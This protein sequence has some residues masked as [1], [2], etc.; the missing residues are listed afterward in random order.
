MKEKSQ[1]KLLLL[2]MSM[3]WFGQYVYFPYQTPYLLAFSVSAGMIGVVI[4]AYGFT[5]LI[6]RIPLGIMADRKPRQKLFIII[7]VACVALASLIRIFSPGEAG[8]LIANLL[9]GIGSSMWIS[10]MT[11]YSNY[12]DKASQQKAMGQALAA[13]NIGILFGFVLASLLYDKMGMT[14]LCI[15]SIAA[16]LIGV[17]LSFFIKEKKAAVKNQ[18]IGQLAAVF[19][20]KRL[21]LFALFAMVVMGVTGATALAFT[22]QVARNLGAG[23]FEIGMASI[24]YMSMSFLGSFFSSTKTAIRQGP[25]IW[26]P[27]MMLFLAVYCFVVPN[28]SS[29]GHVFAIQILVGLSKGILISCCTAEGM[30]NVPLEKKTT[31]IGFFQAIYAVG[32]TFGPVLAGALSDAVNINFAYYMMAA[33]AIAG[34]AGAMFYYYVWQKRSVQVLQ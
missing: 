12:F 30:R 6:V 9:S 3:F 10:F 26:I 15:F 13:N 2:I 23:G 27:V 14:I 32:M 33:A 22:M 1:L 24:I 29:V 34:F 25:K 28:C 21:V 8:F 4:G 31:A 19:L 17:I 20:D 7:G 5:Q 16:S 18:S 11:L